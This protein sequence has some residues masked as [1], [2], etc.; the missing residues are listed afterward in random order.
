MSEKDGTRCFGVQAHEQF[1][2][3]M[4]MSEARF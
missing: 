2:T 1:C 3:D 4:Y